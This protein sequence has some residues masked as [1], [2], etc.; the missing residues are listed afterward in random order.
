MKKL[1]NSIFFLL[2]FV[3]F[4]SQVNLPV[5]A[6]PFDK[7]LKQSD[8]IMNA[9]TIYPSVVI[10]DFNTAEDV[11]LW[12]TG[13]NSKEVNFVTSILNGPNSVFEGS[14][15]LE[16]TPEKV[17]VFEWRTIYRDFETP[18]DLSEQNYVAFASNSWGWQPVDYFIKIKLHSS[19]DSY[20]GIAKM[21]NDRWNQF[22]LSIKE[23]ENRN[24]I[25]KIEFS[26]MQNFDLEGIK[27]GDPGYDFWDGKFQ[28]DHLVATNLLDM[29]FSVDGD[30]EGFTSESSLLQVEN[31]SLQMEIIGSNPVLI[32]P[33]L[34]QDLTMKNIISVDLK[35]ETDADQ[36]KISWTTEED[37]D[38][39]KEKSTTVDV[40]TSDQ[41]KTVN[42]SLSDN[43]I[44][45]GK[46]KQFRMEP[47]VNK[48]EGKIEINKITFDYA[49]FESENYV[50]ELKESKITDTENILISGSVSDEYLVANEDAQLQLFELRPYED[51]E[52]DW[53]S[54]TPISE[55]KVSKD[56]TFEIPLNKGEK[57]RLYSKFV[58]VLKNANGEYELVDDARY[59]TNPEK[60]A[61]NDYSFPEAQSKKGLQ[62]QM[63][64]DA[65][66]LGIS[67]AALN[68]AYDQMLYV[69]DSHPGNTIPYVFE[70]ETFYFKKSTVQS[71]DNQI[72]S[73]SDNDMIVSLILIMYNNMDPSTPNEHLIH[74][75]AE[76]GGTV[77][78]VN[79]ANE[80]GV[81][82]YSAITNFL[83]E[84]YTREDEKF[85]R[86]VNYIVGNEIGQNK[87][88]NNMGPKLVWD[89]VDEYARTLRLT[90][91]IV[92]SNYTNARTYVS[93]DHF[94]DENIPADALWKY[95][96]KR[97][98]NLLNEDIQSQGDISWHIAFHPYPQ[99]LFEPRFWN[100]ALATDDFETDVIT[101]KNLQVLPEYLN[102]EE[103]LY[104]GE[105]RRIIL[106]EQGFHSGDNSEEAQ[107]VQAAAY[108]YAYYKVKFLDEIDSFILHRHVDHRQEGGLNLG[109]WTTA[110]G[111]VVTPDQHKYSYDVFKYIDTERSLEVTEFAK[112][113]IG[114][115]DWQEVIPN[116]NAN[117]LA[118][119]VLPTEV[120][121]SFVKKPIKPLIIENFDQDTGAWESVDNSNSVSRNA[122]STFGGDGALQ[123]HFNSLASLWRGA[124]V[125]FEQPVDVSDTP[126][127]NLALAIPNM[128]EELSYHAKV[129]IYSGSNVAEGILPIH[130][131]D[132]NNIAL[133][134]SK[135]N[136]L[137]SVDRIK[138]WVKSSTLN[139]WNGTLLIDEVS[140]AN[141]VVPQGGKV[142]VNIEMDSKTAIE[143]GDEINVKVTNNDVFN[144][145]GNIKIA[146]S[147]YITF[148]T[149]TIKVNGIKP[150]ESKVF[151]LKVE[152]FTLPNEED[153]KI[154]FNYRNSTWEKMLYKYKNSGGEQ[155]PG[156]I[157][158]LYNFEDD[159]N[160]WKAGGN[161]ANIISTKS[162]ANA[163][164]TAYLGSSV[165]EVTAEGVAATDWK[166]VVIEPETPL[167]LNA[168]TDFFY[169]INSYGGLPNGTYESKLTLYSGEETIS[170][171]KAINPDSWNE[172][173]VNIHDWVGKQEV[174]KIEISFRGVGN[175]M[176]WA[177]KFQLDFIGYQ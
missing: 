45:E 8:N 22:F 137:H 149:N 6:A 18:L 152:E 133:D 138:V 123:V 78:A 81:K 147:N 76:P 29:T 27:P 9:T 129:K 163:P 134:L 67:H 54:I 115:E 34:N 107:K 44:V 17:K 159:V 101:F 104:N 7:D 91:T 96:N 113:I 35:N 3:V 126:Y 156:G 85:G 68:V 125:N 164:T 100:D 11:A 128:D 79:T 26:F 19:E 72:K 93:L 106:S 173:R 120:G 4:I 160:G 167:N 39:D 64:D 40:A 87:V 171:T 55:K 12:K 41:F 33:E 65:E 60:V 124:G 13:E 174:T 158:V 122:E 43:G 32:S 95:D 90:N 141:K 10:N 102:Q 119:R 62:V 155:L 105:P 51:N 42:F 53:D 82:Y 118:D 142:N 74:P 84:R 71:L 75:D 140:F 176:A 16:Q 59:I 36:F 109:V 89:Y 135:W 170:E 136:G 99:N 166:T 24:D 111:Q 131:S 52:Q 30:T 103:F 148:T 69:D 38:W 145:T 58:A 1:R 37:Q 150:G 61:K 86:A 132:W 97:I 162:F 121:V 172:V 14:G 144:L 112:S 31:G 21:S 110:E 46:I 154:S 117:E 70:G 66:E 73:L 151:V 177:P 49:P 92:K 77:Y 94:W 47:L 169:Y 20:E 28:I 175:D 5:K 83:A 50:G 88:W 168:A 2:A 127:L 25:R 63:T 143:K 98:I 56:F 139:N 165:L 153:I 114:I 80:I 130:N 15:A 23:W 48:P 116:F 161:V 108:A 157:T 57:S 146:D